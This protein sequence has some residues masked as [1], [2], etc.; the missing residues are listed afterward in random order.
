[1]VKF[2]TVK[3]GQNG[4]STVNW[5]NFFE[6]GE[7]LSPHPKEMYHA[8]KP[9][10]PAPVTNALLRDDIDDDVSF[11]STRP[12]RSQVMVLNRFFKAAW[13][14]LFPLRLI[15][16]MTALSRAK[17]ASLLET[18]QPSPTSPTDP[19]ES[20]TSFSVAL[21]PSSLFNREVLSLQVRPKQKT[22]LRTVQCG[23]GR[24]D[25]GLP[26]RPQLRNSPKTEAASNISSALELL[27]AAIKARAWAME[28]HRA[29]D[30]TGG[31]VRDITRAF[32]R[33]L[34]DVGISTQVYWCN[35]LTRRDCSRFLEKAPEIFKAMTTALQAKGIP[36]ADI[37][38]YLKKHQEPLSVLLKIVPLISAARLL[39]DN[40]LDELDREA[41]AY[42]ALFRERFKGS[43]LPKVHVLVEHVPAVARRLGSLGLFS[44]E[45]FES[46]HSRY[47]QVRQKCR[48]MRSPTARIAAQQRHL[49][50][51]RL[52]PEIK[53][54]ARKKRRSGAEMQ[55]ARS[56]AAQAK[57]L[58]EG[59][60]AGAG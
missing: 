57:E 30:E 47:E 36:D 17:A 59:A 49:L 14:V 24:R 39:T 18:D 32:D 60:G 15:S 42:G 16:E 29:Q 56:E 34:A 46:A 37:R 33:A 27:Q 10:W 31:N 3:G 51:M 58:T 43:F 20:S 40:E 41:A 19:T 50:A 25:S 4:G 21:Q 23:V 6:G 1:M 55:A 22:D 45:G 28:E 35:S 7:I 11:V 44:E 52:A 9:L 12:L 53:G 54:R 5:A 2:G 48:Q 38:G 26:T 13:R 8:E